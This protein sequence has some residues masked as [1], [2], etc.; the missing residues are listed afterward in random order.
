MTHGGPFP[1][2]NTEVNDYFNLVVPYLSTNATRLGVSTGNT[3]ALDT[4]YDNNGAA[5]QDELGWS[6]LWPLYTNRDTVTPTIR[7]IIQTRKEEMETLLR[8]IYDDIPQSA[9]T[10]NDRSTLTLPLRDTTPTT[11]Q[12]V[13]FAPVISFD[14]V[15]NGI[16][17]VRFQNPKTPD[18]NAMPDNQDCEVQRYV[19]AAGIAENEIP[20]AHFEDTGKHLLQVNYDPSDKGKTAYYR[21]RYKTDTGKTGPWS[22]VQSEIVL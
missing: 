13:D 5:E 1:T 14:K 20:F 15:S 7:E 8:T 16:Q 17:V 18:S 6:Q 4:L 19:G 3:N 10:T 12:A 21:A 9:L 11:I 22:D 2:K